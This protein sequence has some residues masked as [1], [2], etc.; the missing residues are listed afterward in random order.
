MIKPL[1]Y[2]GEID[3]AALLDY[4]NVNT[5]FDNK[6]VS[7]DINFLNTSISEGV[8]QRINAFL[9]NI[10]EFNNQNKSIIE[11]NF[12]EGGEVVDYIQFHL[13]EL[14]EEELASIIDNN[15]SQSKDQQILDSLRLVRIGLY[16]DG[17]YETSYFAVFDYSI[18]IDGDLS[19][20]LVVVKTNERGE[21][22]H[23]TWES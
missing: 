1:P 7:L 6:Q 5:T 22:D 18:E 17:K 3:I 11:R 9:D 4:Y 13:E 2:F 12:K 14:S 10:R 8:Y 23:V 15:D 21:L 16:P 20:Q 19:N